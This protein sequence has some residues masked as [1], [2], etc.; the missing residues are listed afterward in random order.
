MDEADAVPAGLWDWLEQDDPASA[1]TPIDPQQVCCVVVA[2]NGEEWLERHLSSLATLAP[3]PGRIVAVDNGSRDQTLSLLREAEE[4][5]IVDAVVEGESDWGF[6]RAVNQAL[7]GERPDWIWL[8]HDDC[9]PRPDALGDLLSGAASQ[10]AGVVFPK[11]IQP[12]R[13][14]YPDVLA[15][16]G[17]TIT[18]TGRRVLTVEEGDIDQQQSQPEP[19]LGGSTAGMLISGSVWRELD[20][21]SPEL[22]LHRDGVDFGWRANQAGHTVITWPNATIMHRQAGRMNERD[23]ASGHEIDRLSAMRLVA[24]RGPK[25]T[26]KARLVMGSILRSVGFLAAKSPRTSA[27][28]LRAMRRFL[29]SRAAIASLAERPAGETDIAGR[30][31]RPFW[32]VGHVIDRAGNGIAERYRELTANESDTSLDELTGDDFAGGGNQRAYPVSPLLALIAILFIAGL[33]AS[34]SL[35]GA[36]AIAGGGLLPSP[37]TLGQ[38]WEAYLRPTVGAAGSNPP[39]LALAALFSTFAF[40][41]PGWFAL[42]G[43]VAAPLLAALAAYLLLRRLEVPIGLSAGTAG[44][45]AGATL[46]LGIVTAGDVTGMVLAIVTPLFVRAVH[47]ITQDRSSGAERLRSPAVASIWLVIMCAVWPILLPLSTIAAVVWAVLRR[48]RMVDS[49]LLIAAPWLFIAPWLPSMWRWPGRLLTGVDPLA[50]PGGF[51][52]GIAM[53]VGRI[54]PSGLPLWV[55]IVFFVSI[56][57][58]SAYALVR[59]E[60]PRTRRLIMV[61]ISVPLIAGAVISR[62]VVAV[63]GGEARTLLSGWALMVVAALLAP[64]VV[65]RMERDERAP[66]KD[67]KTTGVVLALLGAL[68]AGSWAWTGFQGPVQQN[69]SLLP[70]YVRDVVQSSRETRVLMVDASDTGHVRWNVVDARQPRWGTGERLPVGTQA[71]EYSSLVQVFSG[72]GAPEDLAETLAQ[73]GISHVWTRGLDVDRLAALSNAAGLTRAAADQESDIWTVDGTVSRFQVIENE[74]AE[75][76]TQTY[77]EAGEGPRYLVIAESSDSR[78]RARLGEQELALVPDRPPVTFEIPPGLGGDL[79]VELEPSWRSLVGQIGVMAVLLILALP[80]L[81]GQV[82]ARRGR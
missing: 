13:R 65:L 35:I 39:W 75:F 48:G 27:A 64:I 21:L 49:I 41:N 54:M 2:H 18:S 50:W 26:S 16:I 24:A 22:P 59:L 71:T 60:S 73:H 46:A 43:L 19:V 6:G 36:G 9:A 31:P 32:A 34:R 7:D 68:V 28:E 8:L 5:G 17:Q 45:W 33:V 72:V 77:L 15:E 23:G 81:G 30:R 56:G 58:L 67:L 70:S 38:A 1:G 80:T 47:R 76:V 52:A 63:P 62:M 10:D 53:L 40:G 29:G 61:C 20:G 51:P 42:G 4:Q 78:W 57:V 14:N 3:R 44:A 66:S 25:A 12:E 11:L 82:S 74:E 69:P 37:E 79:V 55:N